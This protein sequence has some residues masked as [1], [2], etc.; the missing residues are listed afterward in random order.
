MFEGGLQLSWQQQVP[1]SDIAAVSLCVSCAG[2]NV[3]FL[4]MLSME[5]GATSVVKTPQLQ[6]QRQGN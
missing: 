3:M 2:E 5:A 4:T 1:L 6:Q